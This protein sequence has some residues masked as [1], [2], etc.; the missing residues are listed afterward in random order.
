MSSGTESSDE[1]LSAFLVHRPQ[2]NSVQEHVVSRLVLICAEE[3]E[4]GGG[5]C[6]RVHAVEPL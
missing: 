3:D 4:D 2:S 6:G 1:V 5:G